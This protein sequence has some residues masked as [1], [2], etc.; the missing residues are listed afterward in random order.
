MGD[1]DRVG[2]PFPSGPRTSPEQETPS[3]APPLSTPPQAPLGF[4]PQGSLGQEGGLGGDP[5]VP[6]PGVE[7]LWG[8]SCWPHPCWGDGSCSF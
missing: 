3:E 6:S 4:C 1:G 5:E 8:H 2:S 7:A